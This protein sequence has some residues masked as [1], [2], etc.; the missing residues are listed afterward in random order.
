VGVVPGLVRVF[1]WTS[2]LLTW[3][4]TALA[5]PQSHG[6][7]SV[8]FAIDGKPAHC[9][10][11]GVELRLDGETIKPDQSGAGFDIPDVFKKALEQWHDDQ[12]VDISL[13]C[14]GR[15]LFFQSC[16]RLL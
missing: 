13:S 4:T 6:S 8:A 9:N 16:T 15:T 11:F 7:I 3:M 5:Q 10:R 1:A 14:N 12:R 2:V